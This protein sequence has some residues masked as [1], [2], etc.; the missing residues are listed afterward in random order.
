[1]ALWMQLTTQLEE[2][3]K[4]EDERFQKASKRSWE[5]NAAL[6]R[7]EMA[8]ETLTSSDGDDDGT[9]AKEEEIF[10]KLVRETVLSPD[11]YNNI[12]HDSSTSA[13]GETEVHQRAPRLGGSLSYKLEDYARYKAF[14]HFLSEEKLLSPNAPCFITTENGTQRNIL[15]DEE[16]LG[17][18]C[19]GLCHDLAKYGV[20]RASNAVD[21]AAAV[22]FIKRARDAVSLILEELLE[23]DFRN[24]PL[25]RK[26]DSTKYA[27]KTIEMVLYELSVAGA[28]GGHKGLV[29]NEEDVD[30]GPVKKMKIADEDKNEA[31]DV[32]M[33]EK[34]EE[35]LAI[36][37]KE[38]GA[39][40]ER[41]DHRDKLREI[42][43][44]TCRDGQKGAKQAIFAMHRGDANRASKLLND[45]ENCVKNDLIPI[46]EEEP[47]LRYGSFSGVLEE[48]VEGKLFYAWL[49][50]DGDNTSNGLNQAVGKILLPDE[51]PLKISTEDYLGGLCDLTGEIG[52]FAVARGTVRDKESVKLCLESN[53][54]IY[55]TLKMLGK[56]PKNISKKMGMVTKSVEKLERVLYEQSLMEMTGRKEFASGVEV[57]GFDNDGGED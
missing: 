22:P 23:F 5:L 38:I 26:Y 40:R 16:Y 13:E 34:A 47:T 3:I 4:T 46:L 9:L 57:K 35:S 29:G 30:G 32:T 15:T 10:D 24:G 44:K 52:R 17:G 7:C 51:I 25:R 6:V 2:R 14:H 49:H 50:G 20:T 1:M 12:V 45:C 41:M 42:L 39:L 54:S 56:L 48:Y 55:M 43:I 18:A 31:E 53:K 37:K 11:M 33:Q 36:P 19:I 8:H 21:D 27:L 28:V